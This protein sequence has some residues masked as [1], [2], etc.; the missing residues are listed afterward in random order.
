MIEDWV[1]STD[2]LWGDS[3]NLTINSPP[4]LVA[5]DS[6]YM[7]ARLTMESVTTLATIGG[8]NLDTFVVQQISREGEILPNLEASTSRGPNIDLETN[9][10][11]V[12]WDSLSDAI[13]DL[14]IDVIQAYN[15]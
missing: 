1:P 12:E 2:L 5:M 14:D 11:E 9:S 3:Q 13:I 15:T 4:I 10:H 8:T 6:D 7:N